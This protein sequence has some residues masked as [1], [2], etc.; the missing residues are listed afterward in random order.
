MHPHNMNKEDGLTLSKS[1]EPFLHML[2]ESRQPPETQYFKLYHS[3]LP[4]LT[5]TQCCFSLTY[6]LLPSTWGLCPP[7][8]VSLLGHAPSPSPLL[9]IS[10]GY[11]QAKPF[12]IKIPQQPH[13]SYSFCLHCLSRWSIQSTPKYRRIKFRHSGIIQ[14]K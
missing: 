1:W 4:Y 7:Q 12:P 5:Q 2:K 6:V 9:L 8:P 3:W 13:H 14:K 10:S 11:F